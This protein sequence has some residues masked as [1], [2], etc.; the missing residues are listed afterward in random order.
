[1]HRKTSSFISS[2]CLI[3]YRPTIHNGILR[4]HRLQEFSQPSVVSSTQQLLCL[5]P[6]R[7]GVI[8]LGSKD[9]LKHLVKP[10][11]LNKGSV[12]VKRFNENESTRPKSQ[13]TT[14]VI[15][16]TGGDDKATSYRL[17]QRD[18]ASRPRTSGTQGH[19]FVLSNVH[20]KHT[21][22][23]RQPYRFSATP[24]SSVLQSR[25]N[26]NAVR[27]HT[28]ERNSTA[29]S[30]ARLQPGTAYRLIEN[31]MK[32]NRKPSARSVDIENV[33]Q[34][35]PY[36]PSFNIQN[37]ATQSRKMAPVLR[38]VPAFPRAAHPVVAKKP[39][40]SPI[41][42]EPVS[43]KRVRFSDQIGLPLVRNATPNYRRKHSYI[44]RW[45]ETAGRP[46]KSLGLPIAS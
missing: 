38:V 35:Y 13:P 17:M 29:V 11:E 21:T 44:L 37:P 33:G 12:H 15:K 10:T 5:T 41:E 23:I 42:T 46:A 1:M 43:Q 8:T 25:S 26:R 9:K 6:S 24:L 18:S 7:G 14:V 32:W 16:T 30:T 19:P 27:L 45:L 3:F 40:K 22:Q 20:Y 34:V 39:P 36:Q 2:N 28:F 4:S 31:H